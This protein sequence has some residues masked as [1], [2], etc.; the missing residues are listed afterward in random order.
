MSHV[1]SHDWKDRGLMGRKAEW[2]PGNTETEVETVTARLGNTTLIFPR[3]SALQNC[4]TSQAQKHIC[5]LFFIPRKPE[6]LSSSGTTKKLVWLT[7]HS[8]T[9]T[10]DLLCLRKLFF[11][12]QLHSSRVARR[13]KCGRPVPAGHSTKLH[14]PLMGWCCS[15]RHQDSLGIKFTSNACEIPRGSVAFMLK[16]F[17]PCPQTDKCSLLRAVRSFHTNDIYVFLMGCNEEVTISKRPAD[18]AKRQEQRKEGLNLQEPQVKKN[19][20]ADG[21]PLNCNCVL[22]PAEYLVIGF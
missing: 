4:P 19:L 11:F 2:D 12:T 15:Y 9:L 3:E 1:D 5:S 20:G 13:G 10:K 17:H 14:P 22:W 7:Q 21:P 18:G 16:Q 6:K 8:Q